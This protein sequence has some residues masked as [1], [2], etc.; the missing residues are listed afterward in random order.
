MSIHPFEQVR[1]SV[2]LRHVPVEKYWSGPAVFLGIHWHQVWAELVVMSAETGEICPL[3]QC[4]NRF[5]P[6]AITLNLIENVFVQTQ[7]RSAH[8]L[9]RSTLVAL[10]VGPI[11]SVLV[12]GRRG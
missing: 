5:V 10:V 1:Y 3:S 7:A 6:S 8:T 11:S 4:T 9:E 12:Q 2:I